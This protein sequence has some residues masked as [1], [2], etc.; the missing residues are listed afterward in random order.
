MVKEF[1]ANNQIYVGTSP[2]STEELQAL[3]DAEL[4]LDPNTRILIRAD[5][6]VEYKT[7]KDLMIAC[8]EV[9]ATDLIY[10]TFEE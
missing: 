6:R 4:E 8:G 2:V 10:A 3:I 5:E 1:H 9:G 7:C